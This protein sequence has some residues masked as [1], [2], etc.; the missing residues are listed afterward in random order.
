MQEPAATHE[1]NQ[2]ATKNA[3][4][5]VERIT[6][7]W[8]L[9]EAAFG[10]LLHAL[11]IPLTGLFIGG[12]AVLFITLIAFFSEKPGTILKATI[13]VMIVKLL[14]SPHSPINAYFAVA[15]QGIAG[16][17]FFRFIKNKRIAAFSLGMLSLLQSGFQ[18]IIVVTLVFGQS[19]WE[20][21]DLFSDY[22]LSQFPI[23]PGTIEEFSLSTTLI[24]IYIGIHILGGI[25]FGLWA[26][27]LAQNVKNGY[28]KSENPVQIKISHDPLPHDT[29]KPKR[30]KLWKRFTYFLV[31]LMALSIVV[32]SYIFPVFEESKGIAALV[33]IIR[34]VVIMTI[35]F[36]AVGPLLMKKLR[37]YLFKKESDHRNE[38]RDILNLLPN[39]KHIIQKS[40]K[41]SPR[42]RNARSLAKFAENLLVYLLSADLSAEK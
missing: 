7:I 23:S 5:P 19:I 37:S 24:I 17:L 8:A 15:F 3:L 6:A 2:T 22:V 35:W 31:I 10:G 9:S 4:Q 28:A 14:A 33:M 25:L 39:I 12:F 42:E 16:E 20:S 32:L 11:H 41:S 13:I 29:P 34:S 18:K 30:R 36:Y 21:I 40:W 1:L 27:V 26:P 38:V